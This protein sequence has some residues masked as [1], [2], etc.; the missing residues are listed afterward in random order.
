MRGEGTIYTENVENMDY[1]IRHLQCIS[2]ILDF[3]KGSCNPLN[4]P[5]GSADAMNPHW[6]M[7]LGS[8][9]DRALHR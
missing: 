4:L 2:S 1:K 5:T 7:W 9:V 8:S 6:T 3:L